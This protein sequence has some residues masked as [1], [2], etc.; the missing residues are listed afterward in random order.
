MTNYIELIVV[1]GFPLE[2][3]GKLRLGEF[4]LIDPFEEYG[5]DAYRYLDGYNMLSQMHFLYSGRG[6]RFLCFRRVFFL[7]GGQNENKDELVRILDN[8]CTRINIAFRLLS[9]RTSH[10][11]VLFG[12]CFDKRII[13][14]DGKELTRIDD[15]QK[16]GFAFVPM[17]GEK[18]EILFSI[19]VLDPVQQQDIFSQVCKYLEGNVADPRK[20]N[21]LRHFYGSM[22]GTQNQ[23]FMSMTICFEMLLIKYRSSKK[24][25]ISQIV[26][27]LLEDD[28]DVISKVILRAEVA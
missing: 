5:Y 12:A 25:P 24:E 8:D 15:T 23:M 20:H 18:C 10:A 17:M 1:E 9:C 26:A 22:F 7:K 16:A 21:I 3:V 11:K 14:D 19:D 13:S 4:E 28:P 6:V 27:H 2:L